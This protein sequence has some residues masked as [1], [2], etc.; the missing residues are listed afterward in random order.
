MKFSTSLRVVSGATVLSVSGELDMSTSPRLREVTIELTA[1]G[2]NDLIVDLNAVEF[3]DSTA[4]SVLVGCL[5]R[6]RA[7]DGS[8]KLACQQPQLLRIFEITG[9]RKVFFIHD[10]VEAALAEFAMTLPESQP[11]DA[12]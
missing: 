12:V 7:T 4:L 9:L 6:V 1:E 3:M 5:R 10:T 8:L 11:L 2:V